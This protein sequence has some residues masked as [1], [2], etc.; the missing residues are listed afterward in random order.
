MSESAV[1]ISKMYFTNSKVS[2]LCFTRF[3]LFFVK[4]RVLQY[5]ILQQ[6]SVETF[7]Y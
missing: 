3:R 2:L 1:H 5:P 4:M 7:D 6:A